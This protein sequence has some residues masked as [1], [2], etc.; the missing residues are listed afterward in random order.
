MKF[1]RKSVITL[2]CI[3]LSAICFF[4]VLNI[5]TMGNDT[6]YQAVEGFY[7]ENKNSL[8]AVFIGSS[9]VWRGW[10]AP[11]AW[12]DYG[13]AVWSYAMPSTHCNAIPFQIKE[14]HKT[15]PEALLIISLNS[16]RN[17]NVSDNMIYRSTSYLRFSPNKLAMIHSLANDAGYTGLDQLQ[18]YFPVIQFHSRWSNLKAWDFLKPVDGLKN[19]S[20][21]IGYLS[22]ITNVTSDYVITDKEKELPEA[23]EKFLEEF[24]EFLDDSGYEVLFVSSPEALGNKS[25]IY[26]RLNRMAVIIQE[27]GYPYLNL[28]NLIDETGIQTET[29]LYDV[30]HVNVHGGIKYT[31]YLAQ[32]LVDNYGFTDKR[33]QPG[34][35]SW[36]ESVSLYT[37]VIAPYTLD[38]EREHAPRDYE[39]KAPILN[40]VKVNDQTL[41]ISWKESPNAEGYD[42][43][44]KSNVSGGKN[45]AY[46]TST[47]SGTLQYVDS[48]L[49]SGKNYTYTVV[50]KK[51]A[52]GVEVY[53]NFDF[54]GVTGTTK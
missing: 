24:L 4:K 50:P 26:Q 36:D 49:K 53:G 12:E 15:Q 33:E 3:I 39:L 42:I 28:I 8:D 40:E 9:H 29:D 30:G 38:F 51:Y 48:G 22:K 34:W 46:L 17:L 44:R 41:T 45:W 43:Y 47:N 52:D 7:H 13:I 27:H 18:F 10:I 14:I 23:Q 35:E 1:K 31:D 20:N 11:L 37:D 6:G 19:G 21:W 32:Y 16:F 54:T 2:I 25:D 5:F